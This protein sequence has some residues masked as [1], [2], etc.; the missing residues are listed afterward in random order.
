LGQDPPTRLK[1]SL[2]LS[3]LALYGL[4]TTIG[5]GIYALTGAVAGEAGMLAPL[6]FAGAAVLAGFTAF[7]FAELSARMPRSA[8]EAVYVRAAFGSDR[9]AL[10][11]G[12]AVVLAGLVST[13]TIANG[14][15]GYL[16]SLLPLPHAP[17]LLLLVGALAG[18][19]FWGVSQSVGMAGVITVIE[20]GGLLFVVAVAGH[21][22]ADLPARLPEILPPAGLG[23]GG[24]AGV[25]LGC[26]L[27]FYAFIGFEDMVNVAEEV[28]DV[29]R[30]LPRAIAITL[31]GTLILYGLLSL[32]AVLAVPPAELARSE[33]PL[34]LVVERAT[35][36]P[37]LAIGLVGMLALVNGA[38]I[39]IVMASRVLYG[40]ADAGELPRV[41][42]RVHPRTRTPH[43]A[44]AGAAGAVTLLALAF[45]LER[46]A[47]ATSVL[48]LGV[49]A[50]V[51]AALVRIRRR[52]GPPPAGQF[53]VP[54]AVPWAGLAV[55]AGALAWRAA[56]ALSAS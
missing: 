26:L 40:L 27:A 30:T 50:A 9:L 49:F 16:Q 1:R 41:L 42:A 4:G 17:A 34:A 52:D 19:A 10:A 12:L 21:H 7:S 45:P 18:L 6:S 36:R 39:Q 24:W 11:V 38:L 28:V 31:A 33:A 47:E 8:G 48:T 55:S 29:R 2:G 46:L 3:L 51:N 20:I 56:L 22:L 5:A 13:A 23:E 14:F 54:L 15:V 32:T 44:T 35:G 53:R 25:G 37:P 43:V